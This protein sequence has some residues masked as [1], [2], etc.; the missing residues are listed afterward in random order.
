M[1][2]LRAVTRTLAFALLCLLATCN[3]R[4]YTPVPPAGTIAPAAID[5]LRYLRHALDQGAGAEM[6]HLFP[7]GYF[8]SHVLYGLAWVDVGL[9]SAEL[10]ATALTEAR[11]ALARLAEPAGTAPFSAALD[12]PHGVF[13]H[14]WRNY[15]LAGT[16]L[17]EPVGT[18]DPAALAD[19]MV[20]SA[21]L[22]AAIERH[23]SPFLPSYPNQAWP[24]DM[25]PAL[26]SLHLFST[27]VDNRYEPLV[28]A[29]LRDARAAVD[30]ATGLLPHRVHPITGAVVDGSRA[31][32]QV[33]ML[34]F[35]A[36]LD[37]AWGAAQYEA[38]RE[39][40]V[41]RR[42]GIPAVREYPPGRDGRGDVDSG[43][44]VTGVS[45]S[46]SAVFLGTARRYAD[47]R[48]ASALWQAGETLGLPLTLSTGRRYLFGALPVGD[49]FV[50]W[51]HTA[52]TWTMSPKPAIAPAP[53]NVFW[54]WPLHGASLAT[55]WLLLRISHRRRER[56]RDDG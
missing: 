21:A 8:F 43:P 16:L 4:L 39:R 18:R 15:L 11:W 48:L 30:P 41:V 40:Y 35:L 32:S 3:A 17:L 26:T 6:Q 50:T 12:P 49:A 7:E 2:I 19:Y 53:A 23:P 33:I 27:V 37:P 5:Q 56:D 25:L 38:F 45:L 47:T 9:Q 20:T 52:T 46:A 36:D 31:T 29:W 42:F 14:G 1:N 51:S 13:Y 34:R 28:A 44:L 24:V 54:R 55:A 22:A 10:T